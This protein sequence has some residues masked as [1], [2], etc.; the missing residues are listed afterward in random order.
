MFD[1][2]AYRSALAF[3]NDCR[4]EAVADAGN[5]R[6]CNLAAA[7]VVVDGMPLIVFAASRP[8]AD[9][10]QMLIDYGAAYWQ[11]AAASG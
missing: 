3:T 4:R 6:P 10:E 7:R 2:G 1:G 8:I 5:W 11:V 9:G